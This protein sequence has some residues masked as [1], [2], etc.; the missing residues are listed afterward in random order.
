MGRVAEGVRAPRNSPQ[1]REQGQEQGQAGR[2]EAAVSIPAGENALQQP[3]QQV[4]FHFN[5][6]F[7]FL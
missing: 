4:N 5:K 6:R 1:T 2:S 3:Q 7:I